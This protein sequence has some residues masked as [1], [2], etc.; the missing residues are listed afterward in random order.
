MNKCNACL[1]L[2]AWVLW[3]KGVLEV[4]G[5]PPRNEGT[6]ILSA[7]PTYEQCEKHFS[8]IIESHRKSGKD[9]FVS[10]TTAYVKE[11][12]SRILYY[13]CLPDTIKDPR[14]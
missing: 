1:L 11:G 13:Q 7:H 4:P 3:A 2:C 9:L 8:Q 6:I 12:D 10:F 5:F 14:F